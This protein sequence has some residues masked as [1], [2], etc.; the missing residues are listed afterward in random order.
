ML[1]EILCDFADTVYRWPDQ[2]KLQGTNALEDAYTQMAWTG[3]LEVPR[4]LMLLADQIV[5][6]QQQVDAARKDPP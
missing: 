1:L 4:I 6:L 2:W 5:A 3:P